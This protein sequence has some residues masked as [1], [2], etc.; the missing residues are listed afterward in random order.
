MLCVVIVKVQFICIQCSFR[1]LTAI[2]ANTCCKWE[3]AVVFPVCLYY[4]VKSFLLSC[5]QG[6]YPW[7]NRV[8][9]YT[10]WNAP[11]VVIEQ[12]NAPNPLSAPL[13]EVHTTMRQGPWDSATQRRQWWALSW[14]GLSWESFVIVG[15]R[16]FQHSSSVQQTDCLLSKQCWT[17]GTKSQSLTSKCGFKGGWRQWATRNTFLAL[18]S[19]PH[20]SPS[21]RPTAGGAQ[22]T[23]TNHS[24]HLSWSSPC[25]AAHL[26]QGW[27]MLEGSSQLCTELSYC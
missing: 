16:C 14:C 19:S 13:H 4:D 5:E 10:F 8:L 27:A 1:S 24:G 25:K 22:K 6:V 23:V 11:S 9:L 20:N 18:H 21:T 15:I 3:N 26:G 7:R 17:Q 12:I 2:L